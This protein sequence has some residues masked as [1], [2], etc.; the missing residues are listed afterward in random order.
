MKK[1]TSKFSPNKKI[2]GAQ[3]IIEL[4]CQNLAKANNEELPI[5]FWENP[6]WGRFY[7]SQLR[8]V[9]KLLEFFPEH[10]LITVIKTYN[11]F[12]LYPK[13]VIDLF[14]KE[15]KKENSIKNIDYDEQISRI[16]N[17]TGKNNININLDYLND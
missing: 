16:T 7:R 13:W 3:Y 1:Y 5:K 12:S 10:V 4:I 17:S 9:H 11:I 15:Y 6:S 8:R 14:I 2:T